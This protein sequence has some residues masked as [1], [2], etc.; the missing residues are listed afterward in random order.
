MSTSRKTVLGEAALAAALVVGLIAL[1]SPHDV[2]LRGF[3]LHP[4]W[5]PVIVLSARYGTRGLFPALVMTVGGLFAIGLFFDGSLEGF[6]ARTRS[7]S[8]LLALATAVLVA[9]VAMA[10]E[11]RTQRA[12]RKLADASD[13]QKQAE[14][15][16]Q[17]LHAS[18]GYLRTR[19]DRLDVSLSLWRS[20]ARRLERGDASDAA[21]AVLELCEIRAGAKAG[22]VQLRDGDR[23]TTLATRGNWPVRLARPGETDGD[24]TVRAAV[25]TS[26][27]TPAAPGSTEIDSDVAIP[28]TDEDSGAVVGVIAL[29]G[30]SPRAMRA[31]DLRDLGVLAQW[32]VPTVT[33][34]LR[35]E[36][37]KA[38]SMLHAPAKPARPKTNGERPRTLT[39]TGV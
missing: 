21:R 22:I 10:H 37:G 14:E 5:L 18:L 38:L 13:A 8:D 25:K 12:H 27:V 36:F 17:A 30:V 34:Q 32:L 24:A 15:N 26:H 31:A 29:R 9:W 28:L 4:M 20:L 11:S 6:A 23:M 35:K 1:A 39:G 16:V 3:G 2:W 33:R 19:H 7:S